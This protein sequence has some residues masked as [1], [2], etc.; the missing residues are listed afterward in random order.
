MDKRGFTLVELTI[1]MSI[2]GLIA[3]LSFLALQSAGAAMAA[4]SVKAGV[5]DNLR[6]VMSAVRTEVQ[7]AAKASDNTLVPALT[8]IA[9]NAA[10]APKCP[11]EIV[12]QRPRN[13]S[14]KLWTSAI[15]FRYYNED[16][17]GNALLDPGEDTDGDK[18]LSRRIQR[19]QDVNGDGD[20]ADP[21]E[22]R[23]SAGTTC[24]TPYLR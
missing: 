4:S 1:S 19:I 21:G 6:D 18:V 23:S 13:A 20:T 10:P 14:G 12:F 15:R 8:K 9:I 3:V 5:Q 11:T 24:R 7:L 17:N 16:T 22:V 2:L